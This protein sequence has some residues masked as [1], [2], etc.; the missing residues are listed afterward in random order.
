ME[1]KNILKTAGTFLVILALMDFGS[2]F[3]FAIPEKYAVIAFIVALVYLGLY[4]LINFKIASG[5]GFTD[6]KK[7]VINKKFTGKLLF[8]KGFMSGLAL[9]APA[10]IIMFF[11]LVLSGNPGV[12]FNLIFNVYLLVVS[13]PMGLM[14]SGIMGFEP[15][16]HPAF[17][18]LASILAVLS[19]GLGYMAGMF[20]QKYLQENIKKELDEIYGENKREKIDI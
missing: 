15:G 13:I 3:L 4:L 11:A 8:F 10:I 20:K 7:Y 1:I 2:L 14:K 17:I 18:L 12:V 5:Y 16:V 9:L 6:Y 19:I